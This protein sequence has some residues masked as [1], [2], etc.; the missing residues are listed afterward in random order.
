M[1]LGGGVRLTSLAPVHATGFKGAAEGSCRPL[2]RLPWGQNLAAPPLLALFLE[3]WGT[4]I[5][6]GPG[7]PRTLPA[8]GRMF[9]SSGWA[10]PRLSL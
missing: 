5:F 6:L 2:S 1:P 10:P 3:W 4:L 8:P 9:P 7:A